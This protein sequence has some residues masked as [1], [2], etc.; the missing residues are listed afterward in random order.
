MKDILT[1]ADHL[2]SVIAHST[3]GFITIVFKKHDFVILDLMLLGID[4][5][6]VIHAL[7]RDP[8]S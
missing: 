5:I 8:P 3:L 2:V 4:G 6:A 1:A 7:R